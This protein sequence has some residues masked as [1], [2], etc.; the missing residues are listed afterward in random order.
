[1]IF[2]PTAEHAEVKL[3]A[4]YPFSELIKTFHQSKPYILLKPVKPFFTFSAC[5]VFKSLVVDF[6]SHTQ[7]RNDLLGL[8]ISDWA[9]WSSH[10]HSV[11]VK[12]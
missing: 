2:A 8:D 1:M 10:S 11:I 9:P 3:E 7:T 4:I 5:M 6:D 12:S